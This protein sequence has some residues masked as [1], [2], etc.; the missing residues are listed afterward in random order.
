MDSPEMNHALPGCFNP[1]END[2]FFGIK[3][4]SGKVA[5][6]YSQAIMDNTLASK[7][8]PVP[9]ALHTDLHRPL[10]SVDAICNPYFYDLYRSPS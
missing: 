1:P 2:A 4:L 7:T 6:R 10:R 9:L 5:V 3:G 8:I